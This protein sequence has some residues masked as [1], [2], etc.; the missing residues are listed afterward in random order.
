[1]R[2]GSRGG[3][4]ILWMRMSLASSSAPNPLWITASAS[5]GGPR[6]KHDE[7]QWY[8]GRKLMPPDLAHHEAHS[9]IVAATMPQTASCTLHRRPLEKHT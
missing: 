8:E 1:M 4:R 3:G 5:P 7:R 2:R 9:G 6:R